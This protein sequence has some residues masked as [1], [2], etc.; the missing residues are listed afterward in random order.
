MEKIICRRKGRIVTEKTRKKLSLANKGRMKPLGFGENI[1]NIMKYK[2]KNNLISDKQI[3]NLFKAEIKA[4]TI[5]PRGMLGKK[6]PKKWK[7]NK[8]NQ[9]KGNTWGFKKGLIPWNKGLKVPAKRKYIWTNH[10]R[11]PISNFVWCSQSE[12]LPHLPKGFVIHHID[13]NAENNEHKNLLL[14]DK[15]SHLK[16]HNQIN[17]I[18]NN[19]RKT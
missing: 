19:R 12:N 6:H 9:M 11:I 10:K 3:N 13:L 2:W 1:S 17:K 18:L 8:S 14:L 4:Y 15:S 5:H 7:L 16:L